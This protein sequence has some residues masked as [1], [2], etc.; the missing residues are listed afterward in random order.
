MANS[1]AHD[2]TPRSDLGLYCLL[3]YIRPN[4]YCPFNITR[5]DAFLAFYFE[6]N[7]FV[8]ID[9]ILSENI[10]V[11]FSNIYTEIEFTAEHQPDLCNVYSEMIFWKYFTQRNIVLL[12]IADSKLLMF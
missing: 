12:F 2:Q 6:W 7:F 5:K 3:K 9:H 8:L 1:V 11:L 10:C 4:K